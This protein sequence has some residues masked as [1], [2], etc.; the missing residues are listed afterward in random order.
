MMKMPAADQ[1]ALLAAHGFGETFA[2]SWIENEDRGE[3]AG[4][5]GLD[6]RSSREA[7][8]EQE[9]APTPDGFLSFNGHDAVWIGPHAPGWSA[10]VGL[11]DDDWFRTA[12]TVFRVS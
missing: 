10:V 5:L 1:Y 8:L 11:S 2:A 7:S 9:E 4:L 6:R 3:I 12:G